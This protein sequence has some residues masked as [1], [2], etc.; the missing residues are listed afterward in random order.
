MTN[1]TQITS[2]FTADLG[3]VKHHVILLAL[4]VLLTFGAVYG[5]E[6]IIARHD[7][8][9]AIVLQTIAQ[10]MQQSNQV[11]QQQNKAQIDAL[12]QQ[13]LQLQQEVSSLAT[14][15][16]TRDTQLQK[17]QAQVPQLSPD[18]LSSEWLARIKNAG[19]IKPILGG[20]QVDQS[21]AVATLQ[22]LESVPVLE[23]DKK[24]LEA[25]IANTAAQLNNETAK[26][27]LEVKSHA[28]DNAA[29][30]AA[31]DAKDAEIKKVKADC[32]K[33]KLKY[34]FIGTAVG[35]IIKAVLL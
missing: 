28:S 18:Q 14:A 35:I 5:V 4:V 23:E 26:F 34:G 33:S 21:A 6:T 16:A 13:N 19:N 9:N 3:W 22:Q 25:E 1:D 30:K 27:D 29:N 11:L 10:Q 20:Y 8:K 7:D 17:T 31:L 2:K 24:D 12:T 15:I 32:R